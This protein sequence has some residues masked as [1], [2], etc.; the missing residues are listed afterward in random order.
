MEY[1]S[2]ERA[3]D[4]WSLPDIMIVRHSADEVAECME[5]DIWEFSKRP[6]FRLASMNRGTR[7]KMINAMID[8]L[9]VTGG[10]MYAFGTPGCLPDSSWFGPFP[11]YAEALSEARANAELED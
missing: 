5:D 2:E 11:T 6:E 10:Y 9:G 8:E 4:K 1:S 7:D 3:N